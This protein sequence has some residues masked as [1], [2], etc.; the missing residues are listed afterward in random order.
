MQVSVHSRAAVEK[1]MVRAD[2]LISICG[3]DQDAPPFNPD[4]FRGEVLPL[5]FDD[6]PVEAWTDR[7]GATWSGPSRGQ[8]IGAIDFARYVITHETTHIAVHCEQGKSRSA[9]IALAVLAA[10]S[11]ATEQEVVATLMTQDVDAQ[12]CFN[13]GIVRHADELLGREG[14][15]EAALAEACPRFVTWRAYWRRQGCIS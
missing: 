10:T 11:S 13:P 1:G 2:A 4:W 3:P 15:L 6:I 12:F 9:A 5:A 14:R 7:H 8:V